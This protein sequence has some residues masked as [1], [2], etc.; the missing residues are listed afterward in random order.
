MQVPKGF[1]VTLFA[2]EPDIKQP[3]AFCIDDRGAVVG[4]G[5]K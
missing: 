4:G 3:I 2:G 1:N 5:G